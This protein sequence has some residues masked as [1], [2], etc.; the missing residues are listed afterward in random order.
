V[1]NVIF[2]DVQEPPGSILPLRVELPQEVVV[3]TVALSALYR[4]SAS[5][6]ETPRVI[7]LEENILQ[8]AV[9]GV[10]C[11]FLFCSSSPACLQPR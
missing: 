2:V 4:L 7:V 1:I 6:K 3:P 9:L 5:A 10:L 8:V 11:Y